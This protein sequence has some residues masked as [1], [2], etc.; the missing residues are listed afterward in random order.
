MGKL[1]IQ[2]YDALLLMRPP[3][4]AVQ[5]GYRGGCLLLIPR[6]AA[7]RIADARSRSGLNIFH[8]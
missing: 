5:A 4:R 8:L 7:V 6:R 2:A 1:G 3:L